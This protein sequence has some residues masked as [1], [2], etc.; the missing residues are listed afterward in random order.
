MTVRTRLMLTWAAIVGLFLLTSL[1][2]V[3]RLTDLRGIAED[4]QG[5]DATASLMLGRL[6][7]SLA[8]LDRYLRSYVALEGDDPELSENVFNT[9]ATANASLTRLGQAGYPDAARQASVRL[10]ALEDASRS[11]VSMV[12]SGRSEDATRYLETVKEALSQSQLA[13]DNLATEIDRRG[14]ARVAR[15]QQMSAAASTTTMV[16]LAI[17]FIIA[18]ALGVWTTRVMTR[19]LREVQTSM[20][21]VADGEFIVPAHLPYARSDEIGDLARSFRTMTGRLADLDRMKAEFISVASHELK[22]PINVI[23]GYAEL[24]EDGVYGPVSDHQRE[25]LDSIQDQ[26]RTLADLVNQILD[27]SRIEAG[28]FRVEKTDVQSRELLQA[29]RRMF[30]PLAKQKRIDLTVEVDDAFPRL[31]HADPDRLRNEVLGNLLSNAFKFTPE[32]GSIHI[33]ARVAPNGDLILEVR[34]TGSGIPEEQLSYIFEKYYQ[35]SGESRMKGSGL[36]L[37]IAREIVE[38][39]SGRIDATSA[40]G[41]GTT[42]TMTFSDLGAPEDGV[43]VAPEEEATPAEDGKAAAGPVPR[44]RTTDGAASRDQA[45]DTGPA[46]DE[47]DAFRLRSRRGEE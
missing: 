38:A 23:G 10:S 46:D 34:D 4:L 24:L 22:T 32:N 6:Q 28:G 29:V 19:P 35:V 14:E 39:H 11:I 37:A 43:A 20:A 9:L 33:S 8:E 1:Y 13:L 5:H 15:A 30:D 45:E 3:A 12:E 21:R 7:T 42:F 41:E 25:A 26:T 40:P 17:A 44:P 31:I 47:R 2:A 16:A 27:I 36:G 18:L